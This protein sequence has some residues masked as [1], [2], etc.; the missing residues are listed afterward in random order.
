[1]YARGT[2]TVV[3]DYCYVP[4]Y[5]TSLLIAF[6]RIREYLDLK[7]YYEKCAE[8][9]ADQ[10]RLACFIEHRVIFFILIIADFE[11]PRITA[12]TLFDFPMHQ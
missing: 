6:T 3:V 4:L 11:K 10:G 12:T 2:I 5:Q 8:H 7:G 9:F 1:M